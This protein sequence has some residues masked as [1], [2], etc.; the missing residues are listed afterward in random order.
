MITSQP[1]GVLLER[2][3]ANRDPEHT[4]STKQ[5]LV[6]IAIEQYI[7]ATGEPCPARY[8][9][10]RLNVHH[11]TIQEYLRVLFLKGWLRTPNAPA[12]LVDRRTA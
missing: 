4:L 11:S 5:R 6:V 8:L 2:R 9:A 10:R 7:G 3:A 12:S 1:D